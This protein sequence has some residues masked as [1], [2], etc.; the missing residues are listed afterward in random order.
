MKEK[1]SIERLEDF[2]KEKGIKYY[3]SSSI[4]NHYLDSGQR[5][6]SSKFIVYDL[7]QRSRNLFLV[8]YDSYSTEAYTSSTYCGLFKR[9]PKCNNEIKII[10]RGWFDF[11]SF[12]KRLKTGDNYIDKHIS[13][14]S[15]AKA[16]DRSIINSKTIR[17]FVE[18]NNEIVGLEL[19]TI[20]ESMSIVPELN[21]NDLVSLQTNNWIKDNDE[22]MMFID[23]GSRLL[24]KIK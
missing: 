12:R 13:I 21:G 22:L 7:N 15:K 8:F 1:T 11:L 19:T 9:I 2:A 4:K 6:T 23:K 20:C 10:K 5:N 14:F 18:I 17:E 24:E 3:T 16:I